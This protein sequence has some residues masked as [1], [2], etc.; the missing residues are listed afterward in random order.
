MNWSCDVT[1][2]NQMS[3]FLFMFTY[4]FIKPMEIWE[5]DL[6][7]LNTLHELIPNCF[8]LSLYSI[9]APIHEVWFQNAI[10]P[11]CVF[12]KNAVKV[13]WKCIRKCLDFGS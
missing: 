11:F 12:E 6:F 9:I 13:T 1:L 10:N 8:L 4:L 7:K 2:A 5:M 3:W